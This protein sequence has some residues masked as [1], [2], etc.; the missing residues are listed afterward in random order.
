MLVMAVTLIT[1]NLKDCQTKE[2]ILLE[3]PIIVLL[4]NFDYYSTKTRVEFGGSCLKQGNV[5]FNHENAVNIYNAYEI[6]KAANVSKYSSDDNYT[7]LQNALFWAVSLT[8]NADFDKYKYSGYGIGFDRRLSFSFP[9]GGVGQNAILFGV[10]MSSSTKIDN[11]KKDIL[12]LGKGPTQGLEH[13]VMMFWWLLMNW[14]TLR[15]WM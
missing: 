13:E 6:S 1:G 5:T 8:K 9:G 7:T 10:D 3:H 4:K 14:K 12:V 2:L 15:Y 11:G